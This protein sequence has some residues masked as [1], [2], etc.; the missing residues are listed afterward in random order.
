[1]SEYITKDG[2]MLDAICFDYYKTELA[3]SEVLEA[4]PDIADNGAIFKAG[5][6]VILPDIYPE[7][8][9]KSLTLW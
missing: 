6:K 3:L 4:N 8:H 9:N 5:I 2:D 1:M 7:K